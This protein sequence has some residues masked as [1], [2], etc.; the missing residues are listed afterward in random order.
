MSVLDCHMINKFRTSNPEMAEI[1]AHMGELESEE[2]FYRFLLLMV[3]LG[4]T[5]LILPQR[6][7]SFQ[8]IM[9]RKAT[10]LLPVCETVFGKLGINSYSQH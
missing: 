5:C 3:F 6:Y 10:S 7:W 8:M 2:E 1:V 4:K 9:K